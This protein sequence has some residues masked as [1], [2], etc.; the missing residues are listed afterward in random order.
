MTSVA[1]VIRWNRRRYPHKRAVVDEHSEMTHLELSDRAWSIAQGLL[2][3][4]VRPGDTVGLMSGNSVFG[5][6]AYLGIA[7]AG[8]V[9]VPYNWRWAVP[10]LAYGIA[11]SGASIVLVEARWEAQVRS[12][13]ETDPGSARQVFVEGS[14]FDAMTG[15]ASDPQ[16]EQEPD[17]INVVL[18]TGGT[19][20]V[21]KGVMLS[22]RNVVANALN[23]IVDTDMSHSDTTL[24]ITP[25]FH[26]ASLLSWFLPHLMLGAT[27][28]LLREFDTR[29]IGQTME[30]ERVTK[31]FFVPSMVRQLLA[32]GIFHEF[33]MS[34]YHRMYV[35]GA[36]FKMSDKKM[37][38]AAL[39]AVDLYYQYGLTE[40]GPIVTR[41]QPDD[42]F[43]PDIDGSIGREFLLTEVSIRGT[44]D[45]VELA[46]GEVG[47][48]CVRGPSVMV[49]YLDRRDATDEAL[50]GGWLRTGDAASVDVEGFV[51]LHDRIKD[52]I[53]SGGENV[54]SQEVERVLYSH[55]AVQEAAVIGVQSEAW[56][57]EVRAVV[58]LWHGREVTEDQLREHCR[59][60]LAGYKIPKR[61][62]FVAASAL[63]INPSGKIVKT[64]LRSRDIW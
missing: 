60:H 48:L 46:P 34:S 64:E 27:S 15:S 29:V 16:V 63:P 58:A 8:A 50:R 35:G 55:P 53:K 13:L 20:G 11:D 36:T 30:R 10:E 17:D 45:D 32:A 38:T 56:D 51:Y 25:M 39:P 6:A 47:E 31:G 33:D 9:A 1:D 3:E 44:V 24:L 49:G 61:I 57:E 14:R 37:I 40:A 42:M 5:V 52:M 54:Y 21:P 19:T 7:A 43:R 4:G 41:M 18:Y 59:P 2:S 22:N 26:S 28:V 12:A 23:E 62:A